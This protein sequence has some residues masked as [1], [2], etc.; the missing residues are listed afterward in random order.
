M[1]DCGLRV[2]E[3]RDVEPRHIT[4]KKDVTS[5]ELEVVAGKDTTGD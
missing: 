1:G 2:A 5:W 4:R 3:V